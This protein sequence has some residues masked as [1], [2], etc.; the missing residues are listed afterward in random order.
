MDARARASGARPEDFIVD[1]LRTLKESRA[2]LEAKLL[3]GVDD[4]DRGEGRA[5]Q[6][7]DWEALRRRVRERFGEDEQ[8]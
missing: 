1:L 6:A 2:E 7:S 8:P 4:L 5:M 3:E